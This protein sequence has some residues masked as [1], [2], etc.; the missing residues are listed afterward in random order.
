MNDFHIPPEWVTGHP[1]RIALIG[2]GGTGSEMLDQLFR[3]N[4]SLLMLGHPGLSITLYDHDAVSEWNLGRQRFWPIDVGSN[5]AKVLADRYNTHWPN[6]KIRYVPRSFDIDYS[7][8]KA[9]LNNYDLLVT[10]VDN[11][12]WRYKLAQQFRDFEKDL[13]PASKDKM[14]Q[15]LWLDSGNDRQTGQIILGHL[16]CPTSSPR[17]PNIVDLYP[18]LAH[19]TDD[20]SES[21]SAEEAFRKQDFGINSQMAVSAGGL[22]WQLLRNGKISHH[23]CFVDRSDLS[24]QSLPISADQWRLFG[25]SA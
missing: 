20:D 9:V 10:C 25:Y 11:G 1:V 6:S 5:K 15:V 14:R 21:C 7:Q 4:V 18:M 3:M 8:C 12:K 19:S 17:L 23:G 24:T 16:L 2:I 22:L 13:T